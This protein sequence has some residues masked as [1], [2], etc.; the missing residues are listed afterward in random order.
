MSVNTQERIG[1]TTVLT[2]QRT[3]LG[4]PKTKQPD[5]FVVNVTCDWLI[6]VGWPRLSL[7]HCK[8]RGCMKVSI[9]TLISSDFLA[10]LLAGKQPEI[11]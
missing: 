6:N 1:F 11:M 2:V 7:L 9:A 4:P 8:Y 3:Q 10:A 5:F